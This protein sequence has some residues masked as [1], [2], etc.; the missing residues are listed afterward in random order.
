MTDDLDAEVVLSSLGNTDGLDTITVGGTIGPWGRR[1]SLQVPR[2]LTEVEA[3]ELIKFVY[4]AIKD[5]RRYQ[6]AGIHAQMLETSGIPLG[7]KH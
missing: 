7:A 5:V 2:D 6:V 3:V 1:V 4:L